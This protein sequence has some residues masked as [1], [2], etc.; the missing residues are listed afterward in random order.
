MLYAII[1]CS[2]PIFWYV[3]HK[4]FSAFVAFGSQALWSHPFNKDGN[5]PPMYILNTDVYSS[6]CKHV[7]VACQQIFILNLET[8]MPICSWYQP[9]IVLVQYIIIIFYYTQK[10]LLH[11][12]QQ[13]S[14]PTQRL[15]AV[16]VT[17]LWHLLSDNI[18]FTDHFSSL[19]KFNDQV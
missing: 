2:S 14:S 7:H 1:G 6:T 15:A 4:Q 19:A 3:K 17:Y 5:L 11:F 13:A 16:H 10:R 12:I 18:K 8:V 9:C